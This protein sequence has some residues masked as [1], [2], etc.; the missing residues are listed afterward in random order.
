MVGEMLKPYLTTRPRLW[1]RV[2][3]KRAG[4]TT[5]DE[6]TCRRPLWRLIHQDREWRGW[7]LHKR[8]RGRESERERERER[9]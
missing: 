9:E 2:L 7:D 8:A 5:F 3:Q 1:R 4:Y 6:N